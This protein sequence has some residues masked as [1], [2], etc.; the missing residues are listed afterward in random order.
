MTRRLLWTHLCA[1]AAGWALARTPENGTPALLT[2]TLALTAASAVALARWAARPL[3]AVA[4]ASHRTAAHLEDLLTSQRAFAGEASHQLKTP[5]AALRL[6]LENLEPALSPQARRTLTSAVTE[7]DRLA[8]MVEALLA[9]ARLEEQGSAPA[10][11]DVGASCVE[12]HSAWHPLFAREGV[13]LVLFAGSVGPVLALP[14]AVE[15]ILDNLLSNALRA[16]PAGS[17]VTIEL[18]LH[19]PTRRP[20]RD[21]RPCWV[22]L[23]VTDEGPG[24]TPA[25]RSHAFTRFW[26]APDAPKGG[27]GLGLSL[28]QRLARA[29]GGDVALRAATTGGVDAVVRLPSAQPPHE[30]PAGSTPCRTLQARS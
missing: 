17:T 21:S 27:T 16:S 13:S 7:T 25:Q 3:H 18:R 5:L 20:L 4:E 24:M 14:G 23:H 11:V 1:A 15:Q 30:Q 19:T 6:R 22:D 2:L 12:R 8:R 29:S 9:M 26:R 10:P 28:V